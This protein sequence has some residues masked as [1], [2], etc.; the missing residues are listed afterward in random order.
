MKNMV[1]LEPK[2]WWK[3]DIYR[4]LK[5]SCFELFRNRK[6]DLSLNQKVDRKMT[7]TWSFW[8]FHDISGLEK[9]DFSGS[10]GCNYI[11]NQWQSYYFELFSCDSTNV[12]YT[13]MCSNCDQFYLKQKWDIEQKISKYTIRKIVRV[14]SSIF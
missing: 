12:L 4:L 11:D 7:F 5:H 14:G 3:Q 8:A 1:F 13:L 9:Y 10:V 6:Y 2:S